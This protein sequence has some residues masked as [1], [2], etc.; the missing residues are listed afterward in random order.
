MPKINVSLRSSN[1]IN[2]ALALKPDVRGQRSEIRCQK[3]DD[4]YHKMPISPSNHHAQN[5]VLYTSRALPYAP[6]ALP[7]APRALPHAHSTQ[8]QFL[9]FSASHLPNFQACPAPRNP[10]LAPR[11]SQPASR[12]PP[13]TSA[14][15]PLLKSRQSL[16]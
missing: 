6:R 9:N 3:T 16:L 1:F 14:P 15:V 8:P 7:H 13:F 10:H 11:T 12:N 4:E 5:V 2:T